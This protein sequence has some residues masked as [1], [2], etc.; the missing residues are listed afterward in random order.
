MAIRQI[1]QAILAG[2]SVTGVPPDLL[3][4]AACL[5]LSFPLCGI[6]KRLP[7]KQP[8]L[9]ELYIL[10]CAVFYLLGIF[11]Y[12]SGTL[13]LLADAMFT[14][15]F[16]RTKRYWSFM[17]VVT[18]L[19][20]LAHMLYTH[21]HEQILFDESFSGHYGHSGAQ[22]VLMIKLTSFAW[23][24][25][26]GTHK[27]ESTLSDFQKENRVIQ[28]PPL[29]R[30]LSWAFF[31]PAVLTGPACGY[32]EYSQWLDMTL[33]NDYFAMQDKKHGKTVKRRIPRSGHVALVKALEG[34]LWAYI[35][36]QSGNYISGDM[37]FES[38]YRS[39]SFSWRVLFLWALSFSY[40]MRYYAAWCISE[41]A[42]IHSGLG[43][44]YTTEEGRI[45]WDRVRNVRPLKIETAQNIHGII[46]NWNMNT[47][48][49][50]RYYVFLR[51]TPKGK[52]PGS[53]STLVTFIVSSLWHGILPGYYLMFVLGALMQM[54]GK[55]YRRYLRPV[56]LGTSYKR[57]YDV[58]TWVCTQAALGYA[59]QPFVV[60]E[61]YR[62][63]KVW[64]SVYFYVHVFLLA[65]WFL[66]LG[67]GRRML[68]PYLRTL[69]EELASQAD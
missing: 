56:V 61:L 41:A 51:V 45:R 69:H 24:A 34:S 42:C 43:Y 3:R 23:D 64:A 46:S 14:Y 38:S 54:F 11:S 30:Y 18:F 8:T 16:V 57:A 13:H 50:L 44:N 60:L 26:D 36:M 55:I 25:F 63:L 37:L 21:Y 53:L 2:A 33:F 10:A 32:R 19:V 58:L 39:L 17:P 48:K 28:M 59:V 15:V 49:W 5:F 52:K 68:V 27:D 31:F 9:K 67:P 65:S 66:F 12:T 1:D 4:V 7:S 40:R 29:L 6:L 22:M 20:L 62:S 47:S 35:F